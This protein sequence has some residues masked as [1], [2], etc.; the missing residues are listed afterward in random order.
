MPASNDFFSLN[1]TTGSLSLLL[2][3]GHCFTT[4]TS[5]KEFA[6]NIPMIFRF[7]IIYKKRIENGSQQKKAIF[8]NTY[9]WTVHLDTYGWMPITLSKTIESDI[10]WMNLFI[11]I[12]YLFSH[13][14][15]SK[16]T[17]Y[18]ISECEIHMK[19]IVEKNVPR[20]SRLFVSIPSSSQR[21]DYSSIWLYYELNFIKH[22]CCSLKTTFD[23]C[24]ITCGFLTIEVPL[25]GILVI[26][27]PI[28]L[29]FFS[30]FDEM[31]MADLAFCSSFS[32]CPVKL[33]WKG[34]QLGHLL[35][36]SV[37][38]LLGYYFQVS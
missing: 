12:L 35:F 20:W 19:Q 26:A 13:L 4:N 36:G 30:Y 16:V 38:N 9:C 6:T 34:F 11:L 25:F 37:N 33:W 3:P 32:S 1:L 14:L 7:D 29:V 18:K 23:H 22:S 2:L 10:H 5:R 15:T 17:E 28:L 27:V 31:W 8:N 24:L 21:E